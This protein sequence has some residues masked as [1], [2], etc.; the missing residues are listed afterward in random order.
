[1]KLKKLFAMSLVITSVL[2]TGCGATEGEAVDNSAPSQSQESSGGKN[3]P[4]TKENSQGSTDKETKEDTKVEDTEK[5]DQVKEEAKEEVK[6]ETKEAVKEPADLEALAAECVFNVY[7][8]TEDDAYSAGTSFL[9]ESDVH[10]EPLLV[11]AFHYLWPDDA[12]TFTGKELPEY[13]CGGELYNAYT[14]E[15]TGATLKECLIIE[16]ADA[17]PAIDKDVSAFTIQDGDDLKTL[18]LATTPVKEGEKVYLLA[19]LSDTEVY[20]E[21]CVYEGEVAVAENGVIYY[22]LEGKPGTRGAS[23]APIVNE[24]G[25]VVAIHIGSNAMY[26]AGHTAESFLGQI[27]NGKISAVTYE[28]YEELE[29]TE[30][31]YFEREE[32]VSSMFFDVQIDAVTVTD[33]LDGEGYEGY[34]FVVMDISLNAAKTER[35]PVPMYYSDFVLEWEEEYCEPLEQGWT[36]AQLPDEYFV[37]QEVT[38]GQLV[39]LAP[40]EEEELIFSFIDVY[41][42]DNPDETNYDKY[43]GIEIP[44]ENWKR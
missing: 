11:S 39:F 34:H 3:S 35:E 5:K 29:P 17:I 37:T 4:F 38:S 22:T 18:P 15:F 33:T 36:D 16:D 19:Y 44:V 28:P 31:L 41:Y 12:D 7:W 20:H 14:G 1:M 8:Y 40:V 27:N 32:K 23:G 21:N 9:M 10:G 30:Y 6:E 26:Y 13:I 42:M 43:Y 2:L 24:Y 25:E